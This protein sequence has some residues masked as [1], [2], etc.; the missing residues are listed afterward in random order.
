MLTKMQ[1][2]QPTFLY[3]YTTVETLALI[4]N[5]KKLR[6]NS[7]LNVDDLEEVQTRNI[8]QLGKYCFVSCFTDSTEESIPIWNMYS[9]KGS[10]VRI[11]LQT[12]SL[13]QSQNRENQGRQ[14][15]IATGRAVLENLGDEFRLSSENDIIL[16][17]KV[18]YT[19]DED[20]LL[21]M[22][23]FNQSAPFSDEIMR[24]VG[25]YKRNCWSF[26]EEWR[27][28]KIIHP[29]NFDAIAHN[30]DVYTTFNDVELNIEALNNL[31]ITLG[32]NISAGNKV[33]IE[34]LVSNYNSSNEG[35]NITFHDSSLTNRVH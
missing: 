20:V 27:F 29:G 16:S 11:R 4:L 7:L 15:I 9:N 35:A 17:K 2:N 31:Q 14:R 21:P 26:Q 8:A 18:I 5:S 28:I 25:V 22:V 19:D 13:F 24:Y 12:N 3:H 32:Y 10:G 6:F 1:D 30:Q 34:N 23:E 33:I